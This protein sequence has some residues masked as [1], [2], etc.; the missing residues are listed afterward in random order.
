M[1]SDWI[2]TGIFV[3]YLMFCY[4][5]ILSTFW[6][7]N[8][9]LFSNL[10]MLVYSPDVFLLPLV[11]LYFRS[12]AINPIDDSRI[13]MHIWQAL[14]IFLF[15]DDLFSFC[16]RVYFW[17][18]HLCRNVSETNY[19]LYALN[20]I[21]L[22]MQNHFFFFDLVVSYS[23]LTKRTTTSSCG[24]CFTGSCMINKVY[25]ATV[26]LIAS[27]QKNNNKCTQHIRT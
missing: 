10:L 1:G 19:F 21:F 11:F 26:E 24:D 13:E 4:L 27:E 6:C 14:S 23:H 18:P 3:C 9:V 15:S 17:C 22:K 5:Q 16:Y 8:N 25:H 20:Q 2:T 12:Y 7:L